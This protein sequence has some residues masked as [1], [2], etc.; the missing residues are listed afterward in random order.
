MVLCD[1]T[2][3]ML[4]QRKANLVFINFFCVRF[5]WFVD[6]LITQFQNVLGSTLDSNNSSSPIIDCANSLSAPLCMHSRHNE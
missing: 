6:N 5:G 4:F 3:Q 2:S 1:G